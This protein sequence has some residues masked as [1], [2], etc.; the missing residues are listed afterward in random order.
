MKDIIIV[1]AGLSGR[2]LALNL[3]RQAP[4]GGPLT[5]RLIDRGGEHYMGP[6]YSNDA[7]HLL[8][9]VPVARM[10]AWPDDPEHFWRWVRDRGIRAESGSFV[11]RKL[12][13]E[14][15]FELMAEAVSDRADTRVFEHR[16]GEVTDIEIT[17]GRVAVQLSGGESLAADKVVLPLGNF[18]SRHPPV[19]DPAVLQSERYVRNA[20]H[21]TALDLLS[22]DDPVAL[23]GTGQTTVD[24]LVTL[25]KRGHRGKI[26]AI[27]RRGL[28]PMAHRQSEQWPSFYSEIEGA[29]RLLEVSRAIRGQVARAQA[30]GMDPRAVIDSLRPHTQA[31]WSGLPESEKRRFMRHLFRYWEIIRSRIP[32]ES[33]A[34]IDRLRAA[35]QFDVVAGRISTLVDTGREMEIHYARRQAA[36]RGVL[37]AAL[38]VNCVGPESD[39]GKVD[40]PL[41]R[42]LLRR[43]LIRPGPA[44]IGLDATPAGAIMGRGGAPS[45]HLFTLGPIMK[46]VLWEVL[47][48]PEIRVQAQRLA[49]QLLEG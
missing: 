19:G 12:L 49:T 4:S 35:G 7:D 46:G 38:V 11:P 47:A 28:L 14:Y 23:I 33:Q 36:G 37:A 3:L 39:L 43:G 27:S 21:P 6:A 41:V 10:G 9:N 24:L 29:S 2:L 40:Q 17:A 48:V 13:R 34:V 1:G 5:L 45:G 22:P 42:N 31:I 32:P 26:T 15:V 30:S 16:R 20:W 18:P 25:E 44:H 8:L